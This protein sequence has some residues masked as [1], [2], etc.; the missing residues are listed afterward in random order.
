MANW[1]KISGNHVGV[2]Y[3]AV[4]VAGTMAKKTAIEGPK[5]STTNTQATTF[6]AGGQNGLHLRASHHHLLL[7]LDHHHYHPHT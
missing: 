7:P 3:P 4:V 1:L 5:S 6:V 2:S